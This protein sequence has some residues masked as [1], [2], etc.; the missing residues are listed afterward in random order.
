MREGYISKKR[1]GRGIPDDMKYIDET[2][3]G[4]DAV[5]HRLVEYRERERDIENQLERL[6]RIE[7]RLK[8]IG[9]P[10]LS[11]IPKSPSASQDK[12]ADIIAQKIDLE[13]EIKMAV[14]EQRQERNAIESILKKLKHSDERAVIR[15]RYFDGASWEDVVGMLFG[16]KEDFLRKEDTYLRRT[17][18]IHG[19]ALMN[20]AI[21]IQGGK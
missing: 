8:S 21:I 9:S 13:N 15:M 19:S 3:C 12:T 10:A 4:T 11:D 16:G 14:A 20:M 1:G 2:R 18:K 5:K 17:H 6:D 7:L